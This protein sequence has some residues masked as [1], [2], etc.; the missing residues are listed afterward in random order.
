MGVRIL[1]DSDNDVAALYCS[2]TDVAFGP[3]FY[4]DTKSGSEDRAEAFCR[5]FQSEACSWRK[6]EREALGSRD[7]RSLTDTGLQAAYSDWLAQEAAQYLREN[8][9]TCEHCGEP[10]GTCDADCHS[11]SV[12]A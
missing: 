1:F 5:W 12:K 6:Y 4:G 9:P 8:P 3:V 2:T 11:H 7:P 10:I